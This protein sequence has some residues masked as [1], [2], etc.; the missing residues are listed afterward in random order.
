MRGQQP[1]SRFVELTKYHI[2]GVGCHI[3][4]CHQEV[5]LIEAWSKGGWTQ[6]GSQEVGF[7]EGC[8]GGQR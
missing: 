1:S 6:D 3:D 2:N 8:E 5:A 4:L 7:V